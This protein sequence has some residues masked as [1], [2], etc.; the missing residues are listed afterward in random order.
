[1]TDRVTADEHTGI[2]EIVLTAVDVH[3]EAMSDKSYTLTFT[4]NDGSGF[5]LQ[6]DLW[7]TRKPIVMRL[8]DG[9]NTDGVDIE[10]E[11][12]K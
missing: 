9:E 6:A 11:V 8:L 12:W 4:R 5:R 2:D 10:D 7:A 3:I 1:M